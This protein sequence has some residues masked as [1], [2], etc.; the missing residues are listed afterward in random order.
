MI[1]Y[2]DGT[3]EGFLCCVFESFAEKEQPTAILDV[4]RADQFSMFGAKYI[5]IDRQRAERVRV[6]IPNK[7]G[8]EAQELLEKAFLTKASTISDTEPFWKAPF[9]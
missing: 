2:Y 4:N 9:A 5:E 1:Y 3:Y 7:M 6:S 8:L